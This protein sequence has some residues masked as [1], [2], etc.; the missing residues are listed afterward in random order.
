MDA[1]AI[2]TTSARSTCWDEFWIRMKWPM[3]RAAGGV[4]VMRRGLLCETPALALIV[5]LT[6]MRVAVPV[7]TG[8]FAVSVRSYR[9]S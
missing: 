9:M 3:R 4:Q 6:T 2:A 8:L 1:D 7:T 5:V